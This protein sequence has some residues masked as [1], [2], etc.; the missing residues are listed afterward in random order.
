MKKTK[1]LIMTLLVRDED[2]IL[3]K[4]IIFHLNQGVDH[5]VVTDNDSVDGTR[6]ILEKYKKKGVLSYVIESKHTYEQD[7]WVSNMAKNAIR[8]YD[9][10]YVLHCDADEF[11]LSDVGDLKSI[12]FKESS[13][14]LHVPVINYLPPKDTN[15]DGFNFDNY[16][17]IVSLTRGCP[18]VL[19][20]RISS[21][22]LLY[23][24]PEKI[25]TSKKIV[26]IGYGNDS[27][28]FNGEIEEKHTD[29]IHIHHFPIRNWNQFERKVFNG[30]SS[31]KNNPIKNPSIGWHWKSW[32]RIYKNGGLYKE[33][34]KISLKYDFSNY[35]E[36]GIV[37]YS[38]VPFKIKY[39]DIL[40]KLHLTFKF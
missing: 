2:D 35:L 17:Y 26:D 22:L 11:W 14:I 21:D 25:I 29:K 19:K 18:G 20:D 7:V 6:D 10:D 13:D 1:K 28:T 39:A 36:N 34:E 37:K 9:A 31:Y 33:Y 12:I 4:N 27:A 30:G 23:T 24:Y 5:I 32:F 3:E 38:S 8:N 16:N 15:I 40:R